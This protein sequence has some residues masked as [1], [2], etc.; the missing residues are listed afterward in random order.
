MAKTNQK[1]TYSEV[2]GEKMLLLTALIEGAVVMGAELLGAKFIEPYFGSS[3]YTW[4][5][6]LAVTLFGLAGGYYLGGILS[7]KYDEIEILYKSMGVAAILIASMPFI[8]PWVM[9]FMLFSDIRT[10]SVISSLIFIF[11]IMFCLGITS[12]LIIT[13][14]SSSVQNTGKF[15]GTTF[16]I[17]TLGGVITTISLGFF[18]IPS[19]GLRICAVTVAMIAVT[20][21]IVVFLKTRNLKSALA[22][23]SITALLTSLNIVSVL[24]AFPTSKHFNVIHK[25][26]GLAGQLLVID[27]IKK[28]TRLLYVNNISQSYSYLPTGRSAFLYVHR[29]AAYS[30]YKPP[31]SKVL[32]AGLGGGQM[33]NEF[34]ILGFDIIL[35]KKMNPWLL[36]V[37]QA[38]SFNTDTDLDME[39]KK[40]L[41]IDTF[42]LLDISYKM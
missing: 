8:G 2:I 28:E 16:A 36:E 19:L 39:V 11:P 26:D 32:L 5:S 35:D 23:L 13:A 37:N 14:L 4:C 24:S 9:E 21:P 1:T 12:P 34:E 38:P 25:S 29:I 6:V 10:A 42:R 30:S 7:K 18:L 3:L 17:A 40:G 41:L 20:A 22:F 33:V 15:V 31:G 27:Y